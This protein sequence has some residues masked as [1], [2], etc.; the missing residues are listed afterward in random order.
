MRRRDAQRVID[1]ELDHIYGTGLGTPQT[2]SSFFDDGLRRQQDSNLRPVGFEAASPG[3]RHH[4]AG[5][6]RGFRK[7][8]S[9]A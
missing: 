5:S 9:I 4:R 3:S 1:E 6:R 2:V 8:S 7:P